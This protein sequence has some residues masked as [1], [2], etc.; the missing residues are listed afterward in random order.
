MANGSC[1]K[2]NTRYGIKYS[3]TL[4][5][6]SK[7]VCNLLINLLYDIYGN[8]SFKI[9]DTVKS[10]GVYKIVPIKTILKY[11]TEYRNK[12]YNQDKIK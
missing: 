4:N 9:L 3:W 5:N 6:K 10:S 12:F 7:I 11:V 2:Y 1:G 8:N